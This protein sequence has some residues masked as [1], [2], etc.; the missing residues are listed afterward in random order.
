MKKEIKLV[1][2]KSGIMRVTTL[3]E[4]WYAKPSTDGKTG[5]PEYTFVPSSTWIAGYY[6]KGIAFYKWL[7]GRG[8][9]EAEAE[10]NAAGDKG[11]K[12]H[13]AIEDLI[14]GN[15][16]KI[17]A[18]YINNSTEKEEELSVE[19]YDAILSFADFFAK[20]K[21]KP[22]FTE[23]TIWGDEY[24]GT[25]DLIFEALEDYKDRSCELKKGKVYLLD[26][27][28][29]KFIWPEHR[30]Q[31]SS[32]FHGWFGE[33]NEKNV[34]SDIVT[35]GSLILQVGYTKNKA[36]WKLTTIADQYD[37]FLV[38]RQI[39]AN[40]NPDAKPKQKDYPLSVKL[41][42]EK[43]AEKSKVVSKT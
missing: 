4:R 12:V 16:I 22:L 36:G 21:I 15:E 33:G 27:K 13:R 37:L 26:L 29:S 19:E 23:K 3:D 38:A 35:G 9:N 25:L 30:L 42:L 8:W 41:E 14:C 31:L 34:V 2:K 24:G 39:W 1:D 10:R 7:A 11:S 40:E 5:L 17:D 43:P 18:K 32:Y 20:V 28:T 6:P